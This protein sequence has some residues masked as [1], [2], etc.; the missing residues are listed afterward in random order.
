MNSRSLLFRLGYNTAVQLVGK[1]VSVLLG[2]LVVFMLTRYLGVSEYGEYALTFSYLSFFS[3]IADFGLQLVVIR[4]LS[5]KNEVIHGSI[6]STFLGLK[7]ILVLISTLVAILS[8]S[9]FPYSNNLKILIAFGS[10]AVAV[11]NFNTYFTAIF[12]SKIRLDMVTLTDLVAK[13]IT[14]GFIL[15]FVSGRYSLIYII[16]AVLIGNLGSS[17]ISFLILRNYVLIREFKKDIALNLLKVGIPI[18]ITSFLSL[19]YFKIDTVM[20]SIFK[21]SYEV[22]VYSLSYKILENT[23]VAWSFYMAT[24]YPIL[25]SYS[26]DKLKFNK[27]AKNSFLLAISSSI[28]IILIFYFFGN[29]II[30]VFAGNRFSDSLAAL[31]ILALS[32]PFLFLNNVFYYIFFLKN[33]IKVLILGI[34][35]TLAINI[36]LNIIIIPPFGYIGASVV[37]II[38]EIVLFIIYL[39]SIKIS[40]NEY[41]KE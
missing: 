23:I 40:K 12:Q 29:E 13:I 17:L 8:L 6:I 27:L 21:T 25:S 1:V 36:F 14:V 16:G 33:R 2:L 20:L 24:A 28:G 31:N 4:E 19:A 5:H 39:L 9:F 10:V 34:G 26:S 7:I 22:G 30:E 18:G 37:T 3:I 32:L 38:S 11:S 35:A 15:F 41:V